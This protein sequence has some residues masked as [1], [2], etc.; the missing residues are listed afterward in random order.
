[1]EGGKPGGKGRKGEDQWPPGL[2]FIHLVGSEASV[3]RRKR[4]FEEI[5]KGMGS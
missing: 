3:S 2:C 4:D 5:S 1:M